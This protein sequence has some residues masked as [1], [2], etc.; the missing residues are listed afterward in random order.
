MIYFDHVSKQGYVNYWRDSSGSTNIKDINILPKLT[1]PINFTDLT[2]SAVEG[3]HQSDGKEST[4]LSTISE[5]R[6]K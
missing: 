5:N 4:Y 1:K 6:F 3:H 2:V